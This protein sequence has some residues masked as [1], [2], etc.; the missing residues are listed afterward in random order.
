[1]VK[2]HGAGDIKEVLINADIIN[3]EK[4]IVSV[5]FKGRNSSGIVELSEEEAEDLG[6]TLA[7]QSKL[8]KASKILRNEKSK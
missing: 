3:P 1:M 4:R 2:I 7:V 8:L 6:K 5:C